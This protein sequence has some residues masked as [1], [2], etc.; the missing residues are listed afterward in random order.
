MKSTII[1]SLEGGRPMRNLDVMD[2][3]CGH[4][5]YRMLDIVPPFSKIPYFVPKSP[6]AAASA[7]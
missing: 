6:N 3:L 2:M 7:P 5:D 4:L 1:V